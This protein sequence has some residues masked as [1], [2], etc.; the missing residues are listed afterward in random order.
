M[1]KLMIRHI[2]D[3]ERFRASK[4]VKLEL[5]LI[6]EVLMPL[7]RGEVMDLLVIPDFRDKVS[8]VRER[9]LVQQVQY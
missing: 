8:R 3:I 4:E 2:K 6:A 1:I 5:I 9:Y 7:V